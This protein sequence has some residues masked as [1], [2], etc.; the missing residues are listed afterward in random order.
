MV[1]HLLLNGVMEQLI[2][3]AINKEDRYMELLPQIESIISCEEDIVANLANVAAMLKEAF[4]N[5][6]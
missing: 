1:A 4:D 3:N 6:T 2:L 5:R